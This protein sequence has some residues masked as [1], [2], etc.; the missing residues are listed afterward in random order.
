MNTSIKLPSTVTSIGDG[1]F[2]NCSR[3]ASVFIPNSVNSIGNLA[4]SKCGNLLSM[5]IPNSVTK[6][7]ES[8]FVDCSSL[9]FVNLG[10][11]VAEIA[12]S[13]FEN[14][15]LASVVLPPSVEAVGKSAF[16]GNSGLNSIAMGCNV[17]SIGDNAFN[18]SV[19]DDVYITDQQPPKAPINAFS[20]YAGKLHVQGNAAV[21][22]YYDALTC[23][24]KF[25]ASVMSEPTG[26]TMDKWTPIEGKAGEE[27]TL[28]ATL[29]SANVDLPYVFWRSTNPQKAIVDKE[30]KV[31]ILEDINE[32]DD[33]KIIAETLY[34][35]GPVAEFSVKA[36]ALTNFEVV[37]EDKIDVFNLQ[38]FS[39]LR[40]GVIDQVKNLPRG[41]YIV[42]QGDRTRKV[43]IN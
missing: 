23:W 6:I 31:T 4:F 5:T 32:G 41:I 10:N 33:C 26:L 28:T 37:M 30:G 20:R 16:A 39:V 35:N 38:G 3:L 13:T 12:N 43:V 14:C 15:N 19:A 22:A 8:A 42:R 29:V 34:A 40:N 9:S 36:N 24:D 17:E 1:A 21:E 7:G 27:F 25:D 11:S 2:Y 18:G